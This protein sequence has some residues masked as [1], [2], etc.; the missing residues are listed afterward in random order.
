MGRMA[1]KTRRAA[2]VRT[3][4][5]AGVLATCAALLSTGVSGAQAAAPHPAASAKTATPTAPATT[6]VRVSSFNLLG[7]S[8]TV[9]GGDAAKHYTDAIQRMVWATQ[10]MSEHH[11]KIIG[12]QEFQVPQYKKF[13]SLVGNR[14]DLYPGVTMGGV[15]VQNSIAWAK[16][17]WTPVLEKT[18][19]VPYFN[20][21][22]TPMPYVL[23]QNNTTGQ[24]VWVYNSHNPANT[25]GPA[26]EYRNEAVTIE[27]ALV[28]SIEKHYPGVPILDLGDKNDRDLY[29][30]PMLQGTDLQ[31]ADGGAIANGSCV[32]PKSPQIDWIT[33][34]PLVSFSN[35]HAIR[36]ALVSKTTDHHVVFADATLTSA[37][38]A[39]AE[40]VV[41]I[42]IQGL[43]GPALA[44]ARQSPMPNL[45]ALLKQSAYTLNART[46][47]ETV[48][49]TQNIFS[50]L[51][52]R[53]VDKNYGGTG[54]PTHPT[55][56]LAQYAGQYVAGVFDVVHDAGL[57]TGIW[58]SNPVLAHTVA[59]SWSSTAA[60][61]DTTGPDNGRGKI[62]VSATSATDRSAMTGLITDLTQ[63]HT[64][65]A[66]A[67]LS[68][69]D[70]I[71]RIDG[72]DSDRYRAALTSIDGYLG[73]LIAAIQ[74]DPL[75]N[76][77]T[78]VIVTSDHGAV[79][80][81][82]MHATV[83]QAYRVPFI[84]WGD[85]TTAGDLYQLNPAFKD[86]GKSR[87][88]Y[89]AAH[90]PIRVSYLANLVTK[91]L[92]LPQVPSSR[93]DSGRVLR[94]GTGG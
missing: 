74:A 45:R 83:S 8:H 15:P 47:D 71:A 90:Q 65:F 41:A 50:E 23:L 62:S 25:A 89:S 3:I 48:S 28:N 32:M 55:G 70:K 52:S 61:A 11:L 4:A 10:I 91:L 42:N 24:R 51:T 82:S 44:S 81:T 31:A 63:H 43:R 34:N 85:T 57:R 87:V 84:V 80:N 37:A 92:G 59:R 69:A 38:P 33:G 18:K 72:F 86:P 49:S 53:P 22:M 5:A 75:L 73:K 9:K 67:D 35:Y 56:T 17:S 16:S 27:V 40:H 66:F 46:D 14:Y 30:C 94:V 68:A 88:S 20:G 76:G 79:L 12:L 93:M 36:D 21:T 7:Y 60:A 2:L 19:K 29:L 6:T 54:L 13:V 64:A 58:T 77:R 78:T 39:E 1:P 26:Q